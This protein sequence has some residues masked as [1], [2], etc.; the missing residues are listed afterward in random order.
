[1]ETVM[2]EESDTTTDTEID[3]DTHID[4]GRNEDIQTLGRELRRD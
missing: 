1:M 2:Q 3:P 4:R